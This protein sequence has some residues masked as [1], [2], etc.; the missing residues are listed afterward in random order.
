MVTDQ[1]Q[2]EDFGYSARGGLT[3]AE[4][5]LYA[6]CTTRRP[7]LSFAAIL[8]APFFTELVCRLLGAW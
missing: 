8:V 4:L 2:L 7:A 6:N 1:S 5:K 3:D